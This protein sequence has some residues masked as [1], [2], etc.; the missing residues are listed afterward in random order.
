MKDFAKQFVALVYRKGCVSS[1]EVRK[2]VKAVGV[3]YDYV[4]STIHKL[5]KRGIIVSPKRGVYCKPSAGY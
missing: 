5:R 2:L 1:V 4:R 3:N